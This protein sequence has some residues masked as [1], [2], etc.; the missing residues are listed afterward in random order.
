[1]SMGRYVF[2]DPWAWLVLSNRKDVHHEPAT[3]E[4]EEITAAGYRRLPRM[5]VF[6]CGEK[7]PQDFTRLT[8]EYGIRHVT[9]LTSLYFLVKICVILWLAKRTERETIREFPN[10]S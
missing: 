4:Y 3:K 8:Q 10:G 9:L 6:R 7:K 5:Y 1:M 2:V